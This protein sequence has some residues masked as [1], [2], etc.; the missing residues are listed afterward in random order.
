MAP[1]V[2]DQAQ[3][4]MMMVLMPVMMTVFFAQSAA[5][6]CLYYLV[7]NLVGMIQTWWVMKNYKPQPVVV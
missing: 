5:G 7:F 1:A 4:K 2:G 6:L 3:R